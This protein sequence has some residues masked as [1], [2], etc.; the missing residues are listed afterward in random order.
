M[1]IGILTIELDI[2]GNNSL[3]EKRRVIKSLIG[4]VK[5]RFNVS[6]AE[7]G[8]NDKYRRAELGM[9]VVSNE[10]AHANTMLDHVAD[11]IRGDGRVV[12]VHLEMEL[13]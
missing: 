9:S 12:V 10:K 8:E 13:F 1:V 4:R 11:F 2:P 7:V 5:S 6:I 3:K